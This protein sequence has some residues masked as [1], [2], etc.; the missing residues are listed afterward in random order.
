[1]MKNQKLI[2]YK[3]MTIG[4]FEFIGI[5]CFLVFHSRQFREKLNTN[6]IPEK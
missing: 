3:T 4:L 6:P 1:M 2:S 5:S